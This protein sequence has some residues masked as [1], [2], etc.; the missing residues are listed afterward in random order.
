MRRM[1][2][3]EAYQAVLDV[4][5]P[6]RG[7]GFAGVQFRRSVSDGDGLPRG[8]VW[9]GLS[10]RT[11]NSRR[12]GRGAQ[13]YRSLGSTSTFRYWRPHFFARLCE[14][15]NTSSLRPRILDP[16]SSTGTALAP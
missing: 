16:R 14:R 8:G 5:R 1:W 4:R 13:S 3:V 7:V 12:C 6:W 9:F 15:K 11:L 2:F 10:P